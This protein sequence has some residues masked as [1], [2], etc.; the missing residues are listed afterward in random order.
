[1]NEYCKINM[2]FPQFHTLPPILHEQQI[3]YTFT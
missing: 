3:L 1:M 2:Y